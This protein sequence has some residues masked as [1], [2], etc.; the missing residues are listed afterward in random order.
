MITFDTKL[1]KFT[2]PFERMLGF[3]ILGNGTVRSIQRGKNSQ[4]GF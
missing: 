1:A 4:G 2:A 3:T